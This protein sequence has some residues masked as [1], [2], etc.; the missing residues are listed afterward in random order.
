[1]SK[2]YEQF[3][4][5]GQRTT[6]KINLFHQLFWPSYVAQIGNWHSDY[7]VKKTDKQ[8]FISFIEIGWV[9]VEIMTV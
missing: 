7:D 3:K 9:E 4:K 6:L 1:M 2:W 8:D 5:L